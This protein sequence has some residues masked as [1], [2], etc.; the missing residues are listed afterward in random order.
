M[1]EMEN[2]YQIKLEKAESKLEK[3]QSKY[4]RLLAKQTDLEQEYNRINKTIDLNE[5]K[6]NSY[7]TFSITF[8]D[9]NIT[10]ERLKHYLKLTLDIEGDEFF[11]HTFEN[12]AIIGS[13]MQMTQSDSVIFGA[14]EDLTELAKF[15]ISFNSSNKDLKKLSS[16]LRK[17]KM[18]IKEG[19]CKLAD[20]NPFF[21]SIN[22][23]KTA[24]NSEDYAKVSLDK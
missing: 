9:K 11:I 7:G 6:K 15:H 24:V 3:L 2:K 1:Q 14:N 4:D 16:Y 23:G 13:S 22:H 10:E 5:I 20:L 21:L 18:Q 12:E 17:L 8:E 19:N